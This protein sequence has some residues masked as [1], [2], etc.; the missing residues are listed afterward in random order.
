MHQGVVH[1]AQ[2]LGVLK[3]GAASIGPVAAVVSLTLAGRSVAAGILTAPVAQ[4]EGL[5]LAQ[6]Q[7]P[8]AAA[9]MEHVAGP[10]D[11]H[12]RDVGVLGDAA[13]AVAGDL[14]PPVQRSQR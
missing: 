13:C 12:R 8:L 10:V 6:G 4:V 2:E 9:D 1:A 3:I 5:A 7:H 14:R 11:E